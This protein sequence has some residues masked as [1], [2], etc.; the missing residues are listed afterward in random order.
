MRWFSRVIEDNKRIV[1]SLMGV[2]QNTTCAGTKDSMNQSFQRMQAQFPSVPQDNRHLLLETAF[3]AMTYKVVMAGGPL[4][5]GGRPRRARPRTTI[6][7]AVPSAS[8]DVAS[9]PQS[10]TD[11]EMSVGEEALTSMTLAFCSNDAGGAHEPLLQQQRQGRRQLL[12]STNE[13]QMEELGLQTTCE[14]CQ[15]TIPVGQQQEGR[16]PSVKHLVSSLSFNIPSSLSSH[17]SSSNGNNSS[18]NNNNNNKHSVDALVPDNSSRFITPTIATVAT[19]T[20]PTGGKAQKF[21]VELGQGA[22]PDMDKDMGSFDELDF[23]CDDFY[24]MD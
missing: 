13:K 10:N 21:R 24:E 22:D 18:N 20:T 1:K 6:V 8:R 23:D 16:E 4:T 2:Y 7:T 5:L 15:P 17:C 11:A 19:V 3:E 9:L 14:I 12:R